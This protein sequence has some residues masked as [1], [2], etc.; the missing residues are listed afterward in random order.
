MEF[1]SVPFSF[2]VKFMC[3]QRAFSIHWP[4]LL[5]FITRCFAR[6]PQGVGCHATPHTWPRLVAAVDVTFGALGLKMPIQFP[7]KVFG[8]FDPLDLDL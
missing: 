6:Y 2:S 7:K 4:C 5:P 3:Y 1:S 8:T